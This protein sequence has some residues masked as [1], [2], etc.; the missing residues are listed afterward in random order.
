MWVPL[1]TK[2]WT[3][4]GNLQIESSKEFW[5]AGTCVAELQFQSW[6]MWRRVAS[7]EVLTFRRNGNAQSSSTSVL[8]VSVYV[9]VSRSV[10]ALEATISVCASFSPPPHGVRAPSGPRLIVEA[11]LS[12]E[13]HLVFIQCCRSTASFWSGKSESL[14]VLPCRIYQ[15]ITSRYFVVVSSCIAF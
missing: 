11:S 12:R 1:K 2:S 14:W 9:T 4:G 10:S 7:W 3:W 6:R 13:L 8:L 5:G 15:R